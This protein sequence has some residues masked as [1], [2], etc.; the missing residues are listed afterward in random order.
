VHD[1]PWLISQRV[2]IF[3]NVYKIS[4]E[5][6]ADDL[7]VTLGT[8]FWLVCVRVRVCARARRGL[9]VED[10][11]CNLRWDNLVVFELESYAFCAVCRAGE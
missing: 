3:L 7:H 9:R 8:D 11:R 5:C 6:S 2:R 10:L 4:F 1:E